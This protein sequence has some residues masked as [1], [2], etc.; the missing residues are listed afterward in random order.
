MDYMDN[1][2]DNNNKLRTFNM[3]ENNIYQMNF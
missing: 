3:M 1:I 2:Q